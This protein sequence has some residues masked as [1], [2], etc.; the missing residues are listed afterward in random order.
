MAEPSAARE[1]GDRSRATGSEE[2]HA[3]V[4]QLAAESGA[5]TEPGDRDFL[6]LRSNFGRA[7]AQ[8]LKAFGPAEDLCKVPRLTRPL[9]SVLQTLT[10]A[11]AEE[12]IY[13]FELCDMTD[14]GPGTVHT[15]PA[16]ASRLPLNSG[17]EAGRPPGGRVLR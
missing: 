6:D 7:A 16:L 13:G 4:V 1:E 9:R 14:L 2:R 8:L 5:E 12:P 15:A 10:A 3:A 17:H 11:S